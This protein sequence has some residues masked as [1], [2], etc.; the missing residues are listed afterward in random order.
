MTKRLVYGVGINDA[1]YTVQIN[2]FSGIDSKGKKIY[3][4]AWM[5]PFYSTW[6]NMLLRCYSAVYHKKQPTYIDCEVQDSWLRFSNFKKWM[7]AQDWEGKEL[8]KD[9]LFPENKVYSEDYCVFVTKQINTFFSERGAERGEYPIGVGLHKQSGLYRARCG[10]TEGGRYNLGYFKTPEEAH[11]AWLQ[12][13]LEQARI[14]ASKQTDV[15]VAKAIVARYE[16]YKE[17]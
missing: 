1:D 15:R 17:T 14:L 5:C 7:L 10:D 16:N 3:K 8:D 4:L 11:K 9:I 6:H 2:E 13:K 12:C